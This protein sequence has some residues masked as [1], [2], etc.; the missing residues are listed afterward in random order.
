MIL[1]PAAMPQEIDLPQIRAS[2][3]RKWHPYPNVGKRSI[4]V[5]GTSLGYLVADV[6]HLHRLQY[7]TTS[8][9]PKILGGCP[10]GTFRQSPYL[11]GMRV[12]FHLYRWGARVL[13]FPGIYQRSQAVYTMSRG[14]QESAAR[15]RGLLRVGPGDASSSVR[16]VRQ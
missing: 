5:S 9:Q 4:I 8:T 6:S 7:W 14:S 2:G 12:R 1:S 3:E 13:R 15:F 11:R 10:S 16:P